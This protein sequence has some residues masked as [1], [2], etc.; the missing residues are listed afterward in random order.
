MLQGD[1]IRPRAV[2]HPGHLD[3]PPIVGVHDERDTVP[4]GQGGDNDLLDKGESRSP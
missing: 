4:R 3:H 1:L 2:G